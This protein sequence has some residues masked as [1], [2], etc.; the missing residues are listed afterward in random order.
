MKRW[1]LALL[2][3]LAA[4]GVACVV[5]IVRES[6]AAER[7]RAEAPR[8]VEDSTK[9]LRKAAEF[10][11]PDTKSDIRFGRSRSSAQPTPQPTTAP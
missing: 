9:A 8:P 3:L 4:A 11:Q 6:D 5:L 2:L 7:R 1:L 10:L